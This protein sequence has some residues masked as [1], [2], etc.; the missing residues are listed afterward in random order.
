M[1]CEEIK[2]DIFDINRDMRIAPATPS[3]PRLQRVDSGPVRMQGD[4]P[5]HIIYHFC[6]KLDQKDPSVIL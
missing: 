2:P 4:L 5:V 3:L 1:T 6:L